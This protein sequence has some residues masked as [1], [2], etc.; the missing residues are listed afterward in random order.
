MENTV[1]EA[2]NQTDLCIICTEWDEI[3]NLDLDTFSL[4][5][6][7]PIVLDGLELLEIG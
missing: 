2:L 5:M 1:E 3:R 7:T 4:Y 6:K